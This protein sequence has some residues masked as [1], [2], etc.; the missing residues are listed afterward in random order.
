MPSLNH[1]SKS[2][3]G[4]AAEDE[5][6]NGDGARRAPVGDSPGHSGFALGQ[7]GLAAPGAGNVDFS[8]LSDRCHEQVI[9]DHHRNAATVGGP[10]HE[11]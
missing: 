1:Q 9:R 11:I 4:Q 6:R 3:A 5:E 7:Q 10:N 2:E 8:S